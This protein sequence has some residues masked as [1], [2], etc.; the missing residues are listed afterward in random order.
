[1]EWSAAGAVGT[2]WT[3]VGI[4]AS[5]CSS[6]RVAKIGAGCGPFCKKSALTR[7][8]KTAAVDI[9]MA[10]DSRGRCAIAAARRPALSN[11]S[12]SLRLERLR[13]FF[14]PVFYGLWRHDRN[15][16]AGRNRHTRCL[17]SKREPYPDP[18]A[19]SQPA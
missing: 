15:I 13:T 1:M 5:F 19:F 17:A 6:T 12:V 11:L 4:A 7:I 8:A 16:F 2:E 14:H 10:T 18:R 9:K 3:R